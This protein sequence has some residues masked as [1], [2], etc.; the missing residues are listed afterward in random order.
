MG[1][2]GEELLARESTLSLPRPSL[3]PPSPP[4]DCSLLR[5]LTPLRWYSSAAA[6]AVRFEIVGVRCE[7]DDSPQRAGAHAPHRHLRAS[8]S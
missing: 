8:F 5:N 6:A 7:E 4:C 1:R 2:E 3:S